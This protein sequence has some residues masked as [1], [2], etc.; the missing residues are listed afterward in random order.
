MA[1]NSLTCAYLNFDFD[2]QNNSRF[3]T[4][5]PKSPIDLCMDL[6]RG[7]VSPLTAVTCCGHWNSYFLNP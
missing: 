4:Y 5:F 2:G 3:L 6:S 7:F 1:F